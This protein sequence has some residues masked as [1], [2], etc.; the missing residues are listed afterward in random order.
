MPRFVD[1]TGEPVVRPARLYKSISTL[2]I[3]LP[4]LVAL[5]AIILAGAARGQV[6]SNHPRPDVWVTNG[7]VT[8]MAQDS[9]ILY[10]GGAFSYVGPRTGGGAVVDVASGAV[11]T[12]G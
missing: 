3:A 11:S 9:G 7:T 2:H 4:S 6:I 8:T 10:L 12:G 5:L 1:R